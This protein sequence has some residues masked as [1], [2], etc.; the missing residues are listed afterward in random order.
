MRIFDLPAQRSTDAMQFSLRTPQAGRWTLVLALGLDNPGRLQESFTGTIDFTPASITVDNLPTSR[1]ARLIAGQP[2]AVTVHVTNTGVSD[3]VV[4]VDARLTQLVT[5]PVSALSPTTVPLP[6]GT[7]EPRPAWLVPTHSDALT[8]VASST[9]PIGMTM[10]DQ[11]GA[12]EVPAVPAGPTA[13]AHLALPAIAPGVWFGAPAL[14]GPFGN[15]GPP[16]V[17]T[18]MTATAEM[19]A[20]DQAITSDTG[21][22]WLLSV[23][24]SAPP[25]SPLVLGPGDS[26]TIAVTI[27]PT[28]PAGTSVKGFLEVATINPNTISGDTLAAFPYAYRIQ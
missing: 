12:S 17:T 23:D 6:L 1:S 27:T 18:D 7:G 15:G 3:K 22:V 2:V 21:D 28:G 19:N 14:V 11:F 26:G 24:S 16:A 13:T 10:S 9:V 25:F 8:M 20:F 4:F 5:L